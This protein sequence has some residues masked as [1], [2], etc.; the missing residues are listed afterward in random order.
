[1]KILV[2]NSGIY[3]IKYKLIDMPVLKVMV[4]NLI[5]RMG[6]SGEQIKHNY[7]RYDRWERRSLYFYIAY[8]RV[9]LERVNAIVLDPD[10]G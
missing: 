10:I 8:H 3:S 9:G 6:I 1:M 7:F 5:K 2:I 4:K